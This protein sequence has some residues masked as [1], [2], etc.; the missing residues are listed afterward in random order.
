MGRPRQIAKDTYGPATRLHSDRSGVSVIAMAGASVGAQE[1][2]MVPKEKDGSAGIAIAATA[3]R[4]TA[5]RPACCR[6]S[7]RRFSLHS[8]LARTITHASCTAF[9]V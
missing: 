6:A 4:A 5:S 2:R 1:L 3:I 8:F 7:M 9:V